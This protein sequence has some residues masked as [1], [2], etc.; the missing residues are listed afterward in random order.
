LTRACCCKHAHLRPPLTP[1]LLPPPPQAARKWG[2]SSSENLDKLDFSAAPAEGAAD[3]DDD[4]VFTSH[5][6][7]RMDEEDDVIPEEEDEE[8]VDEEEL[9]RQALGQTGGWAW[10]CF[11]MAAVG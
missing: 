6:A 5:Q 7:S 4:E 1:R 11:E 3:D 8:E 2:Y 9:R 10:G